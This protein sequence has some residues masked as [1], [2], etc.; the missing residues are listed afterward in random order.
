MSVQLNVYYSTNARTN[1]DY[2]FYFFSETCTVELS[3]SNTDGSSTMVVS[4]SFLSP[5]EKSHSGKLRISKG[6][7]SFLY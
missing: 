2:Y 4:N 3:G 5:L 1:T 7:F 6:D